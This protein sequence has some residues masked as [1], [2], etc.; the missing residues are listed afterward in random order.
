MWNDLFAAVALLLV[1][2]GIMP[3][4]KPDKWRQYLK[5]I[6]EQPDKTLRIMGLVSM[7]LGAFLLILVRSFDTT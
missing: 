3:F 2:E 6:V 4:I 5:I 1:F 7:L